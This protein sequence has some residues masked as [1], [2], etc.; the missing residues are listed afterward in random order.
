[1]GARKGRGAVSLCGSAAWARPAT[2]DPRSRESP[3][4]TATTL[5]Q[6]RDSDYA[7]CRNR[8]VRWTGSVSIFGMTCSPISRIVWSVSSFGTPTGSPKDS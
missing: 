2:A 3:H 1:M 8:V 6:V 7:P 5:P 4:A